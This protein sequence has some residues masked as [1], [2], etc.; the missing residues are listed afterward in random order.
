[1]LEAIRNRQLI[2]HCVTSEPRHHYCPEF[3][4]LIMTGRSLESESLSGCGLDLK[5]SRM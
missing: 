2:C 4:L 3:H 5:Q 1:M